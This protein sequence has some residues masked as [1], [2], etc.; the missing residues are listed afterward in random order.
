MKFPAMRAG[1]G[2]VLT[3][4][5]SAGV[6]FPAQ[7]ATRVV[8]VDVSNWTGD[9][10]W[11]SVADGGARFAYVHATEGLDYKN[12]RFAAQFGGAGDAGIYRGAYHFAQP[13]ESGGAEQAD[14]FVR[15]GG[16]W[17]AD[18]KTLPGVLDV[19]DNPYKNRNGLDHCYGLDQDE[20]VKWIGDFAKRYKARTH[21]DVVIYTTTAWWRSCT[22]DAKGFGRNPLWLARWGDEV[23]P[24]PASWSKHTF[25][26]S[27]E[28]GNHA[29]G[30]DRF[31]GTATQLRRLAL[32]P[33]SYRVTGQA[34]R[35]NAYTVTVANT[36]PRPVT[37]LSV[38][39]RTFGGNRLVTVPKACRKSATVLRCTI[40]SIAPGR[41]VR[42]T[43]G[44]KPKAGGSVGIHLKVG[45]VK[46]TLRGAAG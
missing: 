28:K 29:G 3:G 2:V 42:I 4:V 22:G 38:Y 39:G 17:A 33:I 24:L 16:R 13:H 46:L 25:W 7:A 11:E 43:L 18:G 10:D 19:E 21:R 32:P 37:E 5:L 9:V 36:G 6:V 15:N 23:G 1:V 35:R 31:H 34:V 40:G 14:F 8:G 41:A 30:E 44:T 27:A 45:S 12:P 20:M 26:Q